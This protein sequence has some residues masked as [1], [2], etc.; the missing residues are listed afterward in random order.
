MNPQQSYDWLEKRNQLSSDKIAIIDYKSGEHLTYQ[1]WNSSVNQT[2]NFLA[3]TVG[4]KRGD[5]VSIIAHNSIEYLDLVFA[6][7]KIGAVLQNISWRLAPGEVV[8]LINH[9]S[10]ACVIY[11]QRSADT[12]EKVTADQLLAVNCQFVAINDPVETDHL[13]FNR[14]R[15][16]SNQ[17]DNFVPV[18]LDAPWMI[19]YTGGTTGLPKGVMISN[20]NALW[21]AIHT[22][23]GWGLAASD[24][25][26]LNM[27]MSHSSGLSVFTLPLVYCGGTSIVCDAFNV[28][29]TFDILENMNP[30]VMVGV[31]TAYTMMQQHAK[32]AEVDLTI[33][34]LAVV[35]GAPCPLT[36]MSKMWE[37]NA[38]FCMGYGL[39]EAGPNNFYLPEKFRKFK[40]ASVGYPV[41]HVDVKLI[42]ENSHTITEPHQMGQLLLRGDHVTKGYWNHPAA[43]MQAID[44]EGWLYTGDVASIDEDGCYNIVGRANDF[45]ISGGENVYPLEVESALYQHP[46][47]VEAVAFGVTDPLWGEVGWAAVH[48][49]DGADVSEAELQAYLANRLAKFKVPKR[50][51]LRSSLPKTPVGK[52]D[53]KAIKQQAASSV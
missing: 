46:D 42:D 49:V 1:Q 9:T 39:T 15:R 4:V 29:D 43:T 35:G 16:F 20:R 34:K 40:P 22:N 10:P 41:L 5:V 23:T 12:I 44:G 50:I 11:D 25:Q 52:L 7:Q 3:K 51:M 2:A 38:N 26:I 30:T 45:Y 6:S 8:N 32:W 21:N 37:K 27:P 31:P 53:R 14:R 18:P 36:V 17:L 13:R 48:C 33:L 47:V 19:C 24:V 28:E